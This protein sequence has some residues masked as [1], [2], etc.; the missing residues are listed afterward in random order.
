MSAHDME[1]LLAVALFAIAGLCI[2]WAVV[3]ISGGRP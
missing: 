1:T 3:R 2:V